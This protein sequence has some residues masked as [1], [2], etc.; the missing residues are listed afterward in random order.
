[1]RKILSA[2]VVT[3]FAV[4]MLL[5]VTRQVN[6]ASVSHSIF[7]QGGTPLP[8]GNGGGGFQ[9]GTPLP[10]GNGGGGFQGGTPLPGGNGGGGFQGGTPLP[11]GNGGG[12]FQGL[13]KTA[14]KNL[15]SGP[16]WLAKAP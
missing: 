6:A 4:T 10:G 8:G 15:E 13:Y 11:G 5:P 9:G 14:N 16:A 1:M 3:A 2:S 7:R 12:G